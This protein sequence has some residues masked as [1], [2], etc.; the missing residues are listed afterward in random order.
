[1]AM[2][3]VAKAARR[4]S[5]AVPFFS[6]VSLISRVSF[7]GSPH[8]VFPAAGATV[9]LLPVGRQGAESSTTCA[10]L[11]RK[12]STCSTLEAKRSRAYEEVGQMERVRGVPRRSEP[13]SPSATPAPDVVRCSTGVSV[14]TNRARH[15]RQ[16]NPLPSRPLPPEPEGRRPEGR[17][18]PTQGLVFRS[19]TR[20]IFDTDRLLAQLVVDDGR[21]GLRLLHVGG[22]S[23]WFFRN[24]TFIVWMLVQ[25]TRG[26]TKQA[27]TCGSCASALEDTASW[28]GWWF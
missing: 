7:D 14:K 18:A 10:K 3:P 20:Y 1:M 12:T 19:P 8:V 24:T 13:N 17:W 27:C 5:D 6:V 16:E 25:I 21:A 22:R 26:S 4:I 28:F 9:Q 11:Q 23:W 2:A 15:R